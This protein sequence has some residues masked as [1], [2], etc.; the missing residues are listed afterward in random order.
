MY[1]IFKV[2]FNFYIIAILIRN[3]TKS[4]HKPWHKTHKSVTNRILKYL[5]RRN[6]ITTLYL[7]AS[8]TEHIFSL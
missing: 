1:F 6:S 7:H 3:H 5:A 2:D 8:I 4:H